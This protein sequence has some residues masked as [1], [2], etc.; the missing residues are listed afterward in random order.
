MR[1]T[2]NVSINLLPAEREALGRLACQRDVSL[3]RLIRDSIQTALRREDPTLARA[4]ARA[5]QAHRERLLD[6][7]LSLGL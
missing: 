4:L 7:Q 3:S 2:I 1:R 6:T 5:R